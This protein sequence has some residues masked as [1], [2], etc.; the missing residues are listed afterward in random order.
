VSTSV[1]WDAW[2]AANAGFWNMPLRCWDLLSSLSSSA[3]GHEKVATP[4]SDK[5]SCHFWTLVASLLGCVNKAESVEQLGAESLVY[6]VLGRRRDGLLDNILICASLQRVSCVG[7]QDTRATYE[8]CP[9]HLAGRGNESKVTRR[10]KYLYSP[11]AGSDPDGGG[12]LAL[13]SPTRNEG[14]HHLP[15]LETREK[16]SI[17]CLVVLS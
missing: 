16:S 17:K 7:L 3:V 5:F 14:A 6:K 9:G 4:N 15:R 10:V 11:N 13:P 12:N 2:M 1:V 8:V